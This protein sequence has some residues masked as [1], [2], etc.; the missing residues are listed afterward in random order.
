VYESTTDG[1]HAVLEAYALQLDY[2][3]S[4]L[5]NLGDD[6]DEFW[7]AT[8]Q[9]IGRKR[10]TLFVLQIIV[11]SVTMAFSF[12]AMVGAIFGMPT[13]IF[14]EGLCSA[15]SGTHTLWPTQYCCHPHRWLDS[16]M[17]S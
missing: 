9:E 17:Y 11:N 1:A 4:Q 3:L 8:Q 12:V 15:H 13:L 5:D 6:I 16:S 10:N 14:L 7:V 2:F